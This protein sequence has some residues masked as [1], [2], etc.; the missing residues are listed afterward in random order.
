MEKKMRQQQ[1]K[2]GNKNINFPVEIM[3]AG[4]VIIKINLDIKEY[5]ATQ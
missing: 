1:G 4:E 5:V 2:A 3:D